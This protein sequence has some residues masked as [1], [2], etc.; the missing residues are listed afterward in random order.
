[1]I[2]MGEASPS[3]S[4]QVITTTVIAKRMAVS[5][6]RAIKELPTLDH[7]NSPPLE[8]VS[9]LGSGPA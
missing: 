7:R 1:M 6:L 2:A 4:G 3:A 8:R 9:S 5:K